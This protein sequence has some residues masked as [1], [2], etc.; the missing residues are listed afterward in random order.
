MEYM[1]NGNLEDLA[2]KQVQKGWDPNMLFKI[3]LGVARGMAHL[4]GSI[5]PI[6]IAELITNI[7]RLA[8][9]GNRSSRLS[10]AQYIIVG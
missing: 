1:P 2:G 6:R 5:Y 8:R 3:T 4:A 7:L 9:G 10:S